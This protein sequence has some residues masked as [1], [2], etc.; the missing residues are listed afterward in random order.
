MGA[1]SGMGS[2]LGLGLGAASLGMSTY[3]SY[4]ETKARNQAAEWN[5]GIAETDALYRDQAA[6]DAIQRGKSQAAIQQL[7]T[8]GQIASDRVKYAASG[9]K[10]NTG[11]PVDVAADT[12]AWGEYER[13]QIVANSEREAWGYRTEA[14]TLRQQAKMTRATKQ[15]PWLSAATT[16]LSGGTSLWQQYSRY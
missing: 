3:S 13:Q 16:G 11:T 10:V 15:N 7:A 1:L 6:D 5:A 12:A 4:Q 8:R 14:N 9:V 2:L